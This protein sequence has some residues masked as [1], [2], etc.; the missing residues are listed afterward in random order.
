MMVSGKVVIIDDDEV[1]ILIMKKELNRAG[2]DHATIE[3]SG[4][5]EGLRLIRD[6]VARGEVPRMVFLDLNMPID[7]GFVFLAAC[8]SEPALSKLPVAMLSTSTRDA[9]QQRAKELGAVAY[10]AK[11]SDREGFERLFREVDPWLQ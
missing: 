9:D 8:N 4:V 5:Q 1:D 7:D 2:Y 3:A 11:P 6:A 10:G